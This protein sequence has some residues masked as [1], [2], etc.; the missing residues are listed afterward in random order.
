M[1]TTVLF[2][3]G[4]TPDGEGKMIEWFSKSVGLPLWAFFIIGMYVIIA[5]TYVTYRLAR[6]LD[7]V[8]HRLY[9]LI[10]SMFP[11]PMKVK[12]NQRVHNKD[13]YTK[14]TMFVVTSETSKA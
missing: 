5:H 6:E 3:F 12:Q 8:F 4:V 2:A 13:D 14:I 9:G 10:V 1:S 11:S 7:G